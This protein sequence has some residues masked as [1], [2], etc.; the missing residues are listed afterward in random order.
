MII[1]L[2]WPTTD[3]SPGTSQ[4]YRRAPRIAVGAMQSLAATIAVAPRAGDATA[5]D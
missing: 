1:E 3:T 2:S 5:A 4:R